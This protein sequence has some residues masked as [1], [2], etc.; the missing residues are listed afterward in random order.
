M[1]RKTKIPNSP[2]EQKPD[3][4]TGATGLLSRAGLLE[5]SDG[6]WMVRRRMLVPSLALLCLFMAQ[7]ILTLEGADP[8]R[9]RITAYIQKSNPAIEPRERDLLA[10]TILRQARTLG[11]KAQGHTIDGQPLLP[12]YFLT[13]V[14]AVESSFQKTVVSRADAHGYMQL[15]TPTARWLAKRMKRRATIDGGGL[16][17]TEENLRIGVAYLVYLFDR[18]ED[19]RKVA[20]AYNAGP[21]NLSRGVYSERYWRKIKRA[22]HGVS[23]R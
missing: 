17:D 7:P 5:L 2:I 10:S 22:Y 6:T 14:I 3:R 13:A 1:S 9:R 18:F 8:T 21:G 16:F 11:E 23:G 19:P 4:P 20:L 12:V 15:Q